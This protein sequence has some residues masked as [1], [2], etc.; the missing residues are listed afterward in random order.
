M[1]KWNKV[2]EQQVA[3]LATDFIEIRSYTGEEREL[4]LFLKNKMLEFGYDEAWI[5]EL[6]NVIGKVVGKKPGKKVLFDGHLDTVVANNT[7]AWKTNPFQAVIAD[8]K[9]Y[10]RGATDMKGALA[11]MI[12]AGALV[13]QNR[14]NFAG[15]YYISGTVHEEIAEGVSLRAVLTRVKPDLVIIGEASE[16]KLNIGQRGRGEILLETFGVPAH[17]ANPQKGKNAV[18]DMCHLVE[19]FRA[20]EMER[21]ELLGAAIMELTDIISEPYPG[22]SIVPA[23]CK[24]TFDRRLLPGDSKQAILA[25][26]EEVIVKTKQK[27]PTIEAK[28]SIA[29]NS[30]KTY[31][32]FPI[33]EDKFAPAWKMEKDA[34]FVVKTLASLRLASIEPILHAYSF[35]TNGSSSAGERHI[36][37]LGF[38]PGREEEA[39]IDNEFIELEQI[40]KAVQGY[41]CLAMN[42]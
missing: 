18:Y 31:T 19:A 36:P 8:G 21:D 1:L 16:L 15:E 30:F 17:S 38:G 10:G 3:D 23:Y 33:D 27:Y 29:K 24:A 9:L 39:H 32:D 41:Y 14:E 6:G 5:D 25:E 37:T 11:A 12:Y 28:V 2:Y 22:T 34:D 26:L 20:H 40:Y 7:K 13:A 4:A 35:C 42:S